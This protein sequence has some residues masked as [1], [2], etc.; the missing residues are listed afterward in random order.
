MEELPWS[1]DIPQEAACSARGDVLRSSGHVGGDVGA[2]SRDGTV[3]YEE[4]R[5][6]QIE[7][8]KQKLLE[9]G[10]AGNY[11]EATGQY[12]CNQL[13]SDQPECIRDGTLI[14]AWLGRPSQLRCD[15][16]WS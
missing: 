11:G 3:L 8:N 5:K 7:L 1:E 6:K 9:L 15:L 2:G 16:E 13:G 10:I 14:A 12:R 4:A